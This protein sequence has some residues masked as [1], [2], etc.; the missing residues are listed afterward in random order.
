[1]NEPPLAIPEQAA[2]LSPRLPR[3]VKILAAA[4]LLNDIATEIVFPLLPDFL[5]TVLKGSKFSLGA[6]EGAADSLASLLK[7][8]SGGL[9]DRV[10]HRKQFVAVGYTLAAFVRPAIGLVIHPWQVLAI[11]MTDRFG[12]GVRAA[13]RDA[14]IA[15]STDHTNRGWAFGFHR[16][17]DHVGAAVGPLLASAFLFFWP[18]E[19]RTLFLLTLIPGLLV[20]ILIWF[21]LREP[22]VIG[23]A[24]EKLRLTQAPFDANFKIFLV[25]LVVFN[26]GNSTDAFLLVRAKE[27]G[28]PK[29]QLPLLWSVFH[30]VKS[31][32]NLMLGRAVDRFGPRPLLYAGWFVYAAVYLAF[33][34][35]TTMLEAWLYFLL[36]ALYYGLAEPAEKTMVTHLVGTARKGLAYGWYNFAIGITMLPAS[37][38]F[39]EIY[40]RFGAFPAFASGAAF[41]LGGMLLLLAV[42]ERPRD[43]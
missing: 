42:R 26:L 28:V 43:L 13:P 4:S 14:L 15:D 2:A 6:I 9:S 16:A 35:A 24:R 29:M 18:D 31:T 20:V 12:K 32:G 1:M 21:G 40:E 17:M 39:G 34:L 8:V 22:A 38:I 30:I 23:P 7:L 33:A 27:L 19:L 3:N 36:Y 41:S 10:G 5:L 11:R 25:A 37:L